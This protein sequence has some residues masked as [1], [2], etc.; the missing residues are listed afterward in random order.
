MSAKK[1]QASLTATITEAASTYCIS[2][3]AQCNFHVRNLPA[4][5]QEKLTLK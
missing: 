1:L 4:Q 3:P 5:E 2:N